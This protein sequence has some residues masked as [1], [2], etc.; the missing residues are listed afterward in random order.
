MISVFHLADTG[1]SMQITFAL[2]GLPLPSAH[3]SLFLLQLA[4]CTAQPLPKQTRAS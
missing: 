3:Q 4:R 2:N 1:D